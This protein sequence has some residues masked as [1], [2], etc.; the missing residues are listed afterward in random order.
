MHNKK[1]KVLRSVL[2]AGQVVK[3]DE[4]FEIDPAQAID[5]ISSGKAIETLEVIEEVVE[6]Q[7]KSKKTTKRKKTTP[8]SE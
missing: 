8:L 6:P 2:W 5:L 1:L 7:V 4:I 3:V